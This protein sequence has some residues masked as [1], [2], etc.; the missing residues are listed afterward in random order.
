[1]PIKRVNADELNLR[2][3]PVVADGNIV[4]V[5]LKATPVDTIGPVDAD[6]WVRTRTTIAGAATEGFVKASLLRDPVAAAR[7]A[8]I[9][10]AVAEW[11]RF[12]KG[13]GEEHK[14]PYYKYVGE[15]WRAIGMDLD[16]RDRD[17]PW[18]AAF[19]SWIVRRAGAPYVGFRFAAAH[20]RYIHQAIRAKL[21]GV[22]SPFWGFQLKDHPVQLGD[23]VCQWR[24]D[25]M[26]YDRAARTDS[27]KSHCDVVVEING[28]AVRAI[29]GN[30][31][32]TVGFKTY[33]RN[34]AGFLKAENNL[35]A[36]LR[37]NT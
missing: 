12:A 17:V 31:S 26:T 10:K 25:E 24:E 1:M 9:E 2:S 22:P 28:L 7:E 11:A 13:R 20:A 36:V 37:N 15:M 19:I 21:D 29:G 35:F 33:A 34:P 14:S 30:N 3:A 16:G 18:S 5:L 8:L 4:A 6:G 27:F 32:H 23:L